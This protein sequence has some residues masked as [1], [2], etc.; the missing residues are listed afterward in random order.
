[1][2]PHPSN[3]PRSPM[4]NSPSVMKSPMGVQ[5]TNQVP[6]GMGQGPGMQ[7]MEQPGMMQGCP[8]SAGPGSAPPSDWNAMSQ[9]SGV[10]SDK[11]LA[12]SM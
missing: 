2:S 1:M 12:N 5:L 3:I 6:Y 11:F 7:P 9:P 4:V 8:R 10:S